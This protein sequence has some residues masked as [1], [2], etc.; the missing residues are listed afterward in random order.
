VLRGLFLVGLFQILLVIVL[1]GSLVSFE[2]Y[3]L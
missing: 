2:T 1:I 3:R